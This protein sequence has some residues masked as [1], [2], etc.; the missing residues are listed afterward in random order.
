LQQNS[1]ELG[2]LY[3]CTK[4]VK[5]ALKHLDYKFKE[6]AKHLFSILDS[7]TE[8]TVLTTGKFMNT[9]W[10][11]F[12]HIMLSRIDLYKLK[13]EL[14]EVGINFDENIEYSGKTIMISY[15]NRIQLTLSFTINRLRKRTVSKVI[16]RV[17]SDVDR[18]CCDVVFY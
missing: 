5:E 11:R 14:F 4:L 2:E 13:H 3:V 8:N 16:C 6:S 12:H 7:V 9:L 17:E 10:K 18:C 1:L 15:F